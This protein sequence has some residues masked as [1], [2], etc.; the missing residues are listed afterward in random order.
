MTKINELISEM[1]T[2]MHKKYDSY[3]YPCGYLESMVKQMVAEMP[4]KQQ[5][6]WIKQIQET[7]EEHK[8]ALL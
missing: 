2:V 1:S 7:V 6:Y 5:A 8:K 4:K 3:A